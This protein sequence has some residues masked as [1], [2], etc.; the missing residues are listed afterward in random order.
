MARAIGLPYLPITL[1]QIIFGP[2]VGTFMYLPAKFRI[3]VLEP[4]H[5]DVE[6]ERER[7]P[8][9]RVMEEAEA[10]RVKLQEALY[11]ML[12]DRHDPWRG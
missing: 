4:V 5:F 10:I 2:V 11:E 9:S 7:Y 6:P 8:R 1:N 12:R 3:R